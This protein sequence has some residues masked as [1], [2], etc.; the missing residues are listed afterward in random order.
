[1]VRDTNTPGKVVVTADIDDDY[2]RFSN[3][4]IEVKDADGNDIAFEK[5]TRQGDLYDGSITFTVIKSQTI[6]ITATD[7]RG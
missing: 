4:V 6:T 3:L 5:E 7:D 2:T 1:M